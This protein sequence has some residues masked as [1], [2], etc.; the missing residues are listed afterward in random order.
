MKGMDLECIKQGS[1]SE[2]N[3]E[4]RRMGLT[5]CLHSSNGDADIENR[6]TDNGGEQEGE[7]HEWREQHG[8]THT[9]I[10]KYTTSGIC[11]MTQGTQ[12][13]AL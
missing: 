2:K 1:Q 6:L 5:N 7:G 10:C 9:N 11:C 8:C 12:T 4:L 13:G 3:M